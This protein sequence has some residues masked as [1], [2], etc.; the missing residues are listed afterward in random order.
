MTR[1]GSVG[2]G[3]QRSR[4]GVLPEQSDQ[5]L[6]I[7]HSEGHGS[8]AGKYSPLPHGPHADPGGVLVGQF[9]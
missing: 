4:I 5:I 9:V 1:P 3:A 7:V 2:S 8:S 6:K